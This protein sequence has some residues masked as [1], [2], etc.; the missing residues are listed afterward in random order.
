MIVIA[1]MFKAKVKM[2]V[3]QVALVVEAMIEVVSIEIVAIEVAAQGVAEEDK[4]GVEDGVEEEEY[5]NEDS[6]M[7]A[8]DVESM[9]K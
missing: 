4:V 6:G 9:A 1:M 5:H 7:A 3:R 2:I 8:R